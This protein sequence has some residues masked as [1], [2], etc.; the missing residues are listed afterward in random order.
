MDIT[1][2]DVVFGSTVLATGPVAT[3][4]AGRL[5]NTDAEVAVKMYADRFD[6]DTVTRHHRERQA[7]HSVRSVRSILPIDDLV[8]HPDGRSGVRME[9]C[10]GSLAGMLDAGGDPLA[11]GDLLNLGSAVATALAAAHR[12]GVVH[13]GVTPHNV[14]CRQSGEFVLADFG[15]A[16]RERFPRDPMHALEYTSPETLRDDSRSVASD[17][18]GLGAVL[19]AAVTGAPPFP[20]RLGE[21]PGERI[22]RVLR[23]QVPPAQGTAVPAELSDLIGRL[24][25]KNPADRP[26]D[27]ASVASFFQ[28]LHQAMTAPPADQ[29]ALPAQVPITSPTSADRDEATNSDDTISDD[30][31]EL[32]S[33]EQDE[34]DTSGDLDDFDFDDFAGSYPS[35]PTPEG[36]APSV[37]PPAPQEMPP[38]PA[39]ATSPVEP[40][41]TALPEDAGVGRV[42]VYRTGGDTSSDRSKRPSTRWRPGLLVGLGAVVVGLAVVPL[43]LQQGG[44]AQPAA[45]P[46]IV[47]EA[48]Q[49]PPSAAP[50][51]VNLELA[52]PADRGNHVDLTWRAD[53][54]LDFAVVVAGERIDTMV[55]VANRQR[56]MRVPVDPTRR[57]CFQVRATD[58]RHI[59][60][61]D[62]IP[63]RGAQCKL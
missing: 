40:T 28:N 60:T 11:V 8:E 12:V 32:T 14:L 42:L 35:G 44:P 50:P 2:G 43:V 53:G 19:Y 49:A 48:A 45:S 18:Y 57:Y 56:T 5:A 3:V 24:L 47:E 31:N 37:G 9:R 52:P 6:R 38:A 39:V 36:S 30:A 27:A 46:T 20:R 62:P 16:L 22:L 25:A 26:S 63:I 34:K 13:G 23:D 59:Y 29:Q 1:V 21:P 15:L 55:L 10:P 54:D 41:D 33:G 17:L 51:K 58:G 4:Y 7:L 61:T